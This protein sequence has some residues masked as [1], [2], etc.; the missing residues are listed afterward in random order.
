MTKYPLNLIVA[1]LFYKGFI[2]N[3]KVKIWQP[4]YYHFMVFWNRTWNINV[5]KKN[6]NHKSIYNDTVS[7][8]PWSTI[9]STT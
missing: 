5:N 7:G 8:G 6:Q 4:I 1:I 3:H 2:T 9:K